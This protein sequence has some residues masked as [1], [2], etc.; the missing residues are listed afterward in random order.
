M[1]RIEYNRIQGVLDEKGKTV[2]WLQEQLGETIPN[3][4]R[5][6]KNVSQPS[7]EVLFDIAKLLDVDVKDLLVSSMVETVKAENESCVRRIIVSR[8]DYNIQSDKR[9]LIPFVEVSRSTKVYAQ[10]QGLLNR[11]GNIV[12]EPKYDFVVG[13][14]YSEEDLIVMGRYY[15]EP[16][17]PHI[18]CHYDIYSGEGEL[19][20]G[21][22]QDFVMSTNRKLV[23]IFVNTEY[24]YGWGV[25]SSKNSYLIRPGKYDWIS[26]F[27]KGYARIKKGKETNGNTD[28][29]VLWGIVNEEGLDVIPPTYHNICNFYDKEYD[30]VKVQKEK[31]GNYE[32][33][34][35]KELSSVWRSLS[36]IARKAK[37]ERENEI[38]SVK[39]RIEE[40]NE[41]MYWRTY[42]YSHKEYNGVYS[43]DVISDAFDGDPSAC[44]NA[45]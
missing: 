40:Q 13:D 23:T 30:S 4:V 45:D 26:G 33:I 31:D 16:D 20:F 27:H 44:W 17:N 5:W 22:V 3:V 8:Y 32:F 25:A 21:E 38:L 36:A 42:G 1:E 7:I 6:C 18:F 43:D 10:K 15:Q 41:E 29:D 28:A 14:C 9:L 24:E 11:E 12:I 34:S 39:K 2:Y 19:V 35:F 37:E